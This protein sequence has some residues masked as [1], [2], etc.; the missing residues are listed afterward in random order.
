MSLGEVRQARSEDCVRV[1]DDVE[2]IRRHRQRECVRL[3]QELTPHL[4]AA[5]AVERD[6]DCHLARRF[7]VF[8]YLRDDELGLSR[9]IAEPLRGSMIPWLVH[10][11]TAW[12]VREWVPH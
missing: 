1:L 8:R 10:T 9:I 11:K 5:R 6:L 2:R 4:H 7:N 3:L 12:R